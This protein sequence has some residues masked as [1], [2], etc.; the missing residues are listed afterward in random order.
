MYSLKV[1]ERLVPTHSHPARARG[2]PMTSLVAEAL[3]ASVAGQDRSRIAHLIA[4]SERRRG[5]HTLTPK[6]S[7]AAGHAT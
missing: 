7:P 5:V 6:A 1:L 4:T 3:D 2:V